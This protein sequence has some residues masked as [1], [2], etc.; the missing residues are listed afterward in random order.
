MGRGALGHHRHGPDVPEGQLV[1]QKGVFPAET[2]FEHRIGDGS[3]YQRREPDGTWY[4]FRHDPMQ[5]GDEAQKLV[6][7]DLVSAHREE[8]KAALAAIP[9][10]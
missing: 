5:D 9:V 2:C 7:A 6:S 3:I 4:V 8:M 1:Y 10:K